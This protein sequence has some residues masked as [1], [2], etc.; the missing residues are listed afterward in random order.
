MCVEYFR[1]L[2]GD[3]R[4]S[5]STADEARCFSA[6]FDREVSPGEEVTLG[7]LMPRP[8][9]NRVFDSPVELFT[10]GLPTPLLKI[11]EAPREAYAKLEW[12]NPFSASVKDRTVYYLLKSTRGDWVVEVSSGNVAVALSALGNVL[13]KRVKVYLPT[14]GRYVAPFLEYLGA[15]Y[16]ILDVSMTIEALELL[17]KDVREGAAHPNQFAND[18]NFLAHLRTAAELD[19]QLS[20]VGKKPNYIVAALGTSGHASAL[21]FYFGVRYGARLIAVQ[22]KDWIPGIR[23][24]ESGMKWI[25]MVHA[26]IVEVSLREALEGV[27]AFAKRFG[28]LIGPSAGAVYTAFTR[29]TAEGTYVMVFPDSL[30]KYGLMLEQFRQVS[31]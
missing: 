8:K 15:E 29:L 10:A 26:E 17:E 2:I 19:W 25:K 1:R 20:S 4:Y 22:P 3:G 18:I 5:I 12:Y 21:G 11:S 23:R 9:P 27:R 13:G 31:S 7:E 28:L 6:L 30:F 16:Q 14:A 24:V